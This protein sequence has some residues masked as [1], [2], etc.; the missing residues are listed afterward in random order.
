MET[1]NSKL[2]D[3]L[4][5]LL[6]QNNIILDSKKKTQLIAYLALVV[7]WN[8]IHNLTAI[9]DPFQMVSKHLIDSLTLLPFIEGNKIL[10]VGT[11]PGF[12]GIPLAIAMPRRD[13]V[14]LECN[15]K[16]CSF[17]QFAVTQL[18]LSQCSVQ[19]TRVEAYQDALKF[20]TIVSRAFS[21]IEL[22]LSLSQHLLAERGL[23][24]AMKGQYPEKELAALT[25]HYIIDFIK[26]L[27]VHGVDGERHVVGVRMRQQEN[28]E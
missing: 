12:P 8:K 18:G 9:R 6:N 4:Q 20:T 16:K 1:E 14:L 22:F 24:L 10:D 28:N 25:D 21:S 19:S 13:Y 2:S 3:Y 26:Q 23:F 15:Q 17:L 27:T 7:R 11:G 5:E